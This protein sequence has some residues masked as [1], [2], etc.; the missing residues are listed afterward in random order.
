MSSARQLPSLPLAVFRCHFETTEPL[1]LPAYA[2]SAW[3]GAFGHALK[4]TVCVVRRTE[5]PSCLLYRSCVYP[6][7][8]ET[9]PP[10]DSEKMRRYTTAP[11]PFALRIDPR[12]NGSPYALGLTLFGR[13]DRHLPYFIHAL[14]QAG[15]AG[16]SRAS[17]AFELI[18]VEQAD[19]PENPIVYEPGQPLRMTPGRTPA[20]PALPE[21]FEIRIETPLRLKREDHLVTPAQFGFG[22]LFGHL[23]RRLSMLSYFHTDTPLE[24]DFA[25]LAQA[26]RNVPVHEPKLRWHDW[27][28]YSSRQQTAMQM[29]GL[30]GRFELRGEDVETFWPYLWLGQWTHVGKGATMG[31][32]RYRIRAASLPETLADA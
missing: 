2:G 32:G 12:Q 20:I 8:F 27:T 1:R 7:V 22:D 14:D 9:P 10:P 30:L 18:K 21:R 13:A 4:R 5:C 17:Q 28:R 15:K 3:R 24:V 25:A 26:S 16:L 23:L 6:Y 31:L 11:H 19:A 29:G